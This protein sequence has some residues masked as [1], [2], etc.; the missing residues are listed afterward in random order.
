VCVAW[1]AACMP[2]C[3]ETNQ[4]MT[5][6]RRNSWSHRFHNATVFGIIL[7]TVSDTPYGR[8]YTVVAT[9]LNGFSKKGYV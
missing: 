5:Y 3:L 2:L 1:L 9:R 7:C 8:L 4:R 6:G